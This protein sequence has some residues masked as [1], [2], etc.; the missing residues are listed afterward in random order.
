MGR[1]EMFYLLFLVLVPCI[2]GSHFS[3][4]CTV[5]V[6]R[7]KSKPSLPCLAGGEEEAGKHAVNFTRLSYS[8]DDINQFTTHTEIALAP[9]PLLTLW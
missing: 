3:A 1:K 5:I 7:D 9:N 4:M 8:S 6:A 2:T